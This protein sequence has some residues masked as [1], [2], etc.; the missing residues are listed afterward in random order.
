V[1][2][3]CL[4][5]AVA[6]GACSGGEPTPLLAAA[7]V[8]EGPLLVEATSTCG[9]EFVH[10]HGGVGNRELPETMGGGVALFDFDGDGDCDVY[11][12]Q[13]GPMRSHAGPRSGEGA[14]NVLFANDGTGRFE[15]VPDAAG[16]GD[17]G[18]GQGCA[19][20]D[21]DADGLDDLL[22]LNWGENALYRNA[23]GRFEEVVS[24]EGIR[25]LDEWSVSAAFFDAEG[26][27][28]LDLYVVNYVQ[29]PPGSHVMQGMPEGF[30]AYPHPSY[31]PG[32]PDRYYVNASEGGRW[33]GF[34][35]PQGRRM[36]GSGDFPGKGL[37]VVP[38]DA[39]LD[40]YLDLYVANDTVR[41]FLFHNLGDGELEEVGVEVG[42]ALNR[43]GNPEAG[44]GV[45]A[46]DFDGDGDFDLFVTNLSSETNTV[47]FNLLLDERPDGQRATRLEFVDLSARSGLGKPS[48][49]MVGFGALFNDAD[50]DGDLDLFLANG[51]IL[52]NVSELSDTITYAEPN[53]LYLGNGKGRWRLA[54]PRRAGL[55]F[56]APSVSRG[57]ACGDLDG[58]G[59]LDYVF[60]NNVDSPQVFFGGLSGGRWLSLRLEGPP[61]NPR[62]LGAVVRLEDGR[63]ETAVYRV[64]AGR[65]YASASEP[66]LAVGI[67]WGVSAVEIVWPGGRRER[68]SGLSGF[69]GHQR[70]K[71]GTGA[72]V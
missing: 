50:R 40:G 7:A 33:E 69:E 65:S 38:F 24:G 45:D 28:D 71:A 26:D 43:T 1:L 58:D 64:D 39:D 19:V 21:F 52:D 10:L 4:G 30:P 34:R 35:P 60:G 27:G 14:A 2:G 59:D 31:F 61:G 51:H 15:R 25:Q 37:G 17:A 48:F 23:G 67:P 16:A 44:M 9:I 46:G 56:E 47:Y 54:A 55:G 20:G 42:V 8:D 12:T 63:G 66:L 5:A 41:N 11:L 49:E 32:T 18:Y 13:S 6:A 22:S 29:A 68:W 70:L 62:G 72:G 3:A 53:Q 57:L 36:T